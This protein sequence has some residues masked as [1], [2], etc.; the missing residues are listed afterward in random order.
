MVQI[1]QHKQHEDMILQTEHL[2]YFPN[3][4]KATTTDEVLMTQGHTQIHSTG[5]DANLANNQI[6]L[7]NARGYHVPSN[8]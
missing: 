5:L 3:E 7:Q 8:G 4:K 2:T 6:H 1:N